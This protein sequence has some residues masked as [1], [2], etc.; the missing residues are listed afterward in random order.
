MKTLHQIEVSGKRV[1]TRVDF[2][3]PFNKDGTIADDTRILAHLDT[4][5]HLIAHKAKTVLIS[6]TSDTS[7]SLQPIAA[8]LSKVLGKPVTFCDTCIGEKAE[9]AVDALNEGDVILLENLRHNKGE[10]ENDENFAAS[11][12]KLGDIYVNDAF[13]TAHRKHA[14]T[15]AVAKHFDVRAAGMLMG[16]ELATLSKVKENA[17]HPFSVIIGGAKIS[18][19]LGLLKEIINDADDLFIGGA[20]ANTFLKS[21]GF[22]TGT[23]LVEE[24]MLDEAQEILNRAKEVGCKIHLP[25]DVVAATAI[26][27]NGHD[28]ICMVDQVP[29]NQMALD[30]GPITT[31]EWFRALDGS[32]TVLWNGPLGAFEIDRFHTGTTT[33]AHELASMNSSF[34]V[35][36][37]GDT[38]AALKVA[39]VTPRFNL[40]S[41]GGG[42]MLRFFEGEPLPAVDALR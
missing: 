17:E 19:K 32:A 10:K 18:T 20:M 13:A 29:E 11:L 22:S 16:M 5:R 38:I 40:V 6:H 9:D 36:G 4:I 3:V 28:Q 37:G 14:S 27:E 41:T 34:R 23:S 42:A 24:N 15:Y 1:L 8:H 39:G 26:S 25:K 33:I 31:Q 2:N 7:F 30:I 12:A 21:Q 35:V